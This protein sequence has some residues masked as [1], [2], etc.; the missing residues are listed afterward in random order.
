MLTT[1]ALAT[2]LAPLV[3][4]PTAGPHSGQPAPAA[5]H[6]AMGHLRTVVIDP[7]HGGTNTGCLGVDGTF[8]KIL[9]MQ[10]AERVARILTEETSAVALLTRQDDTYLGLRE[11]TRQANAWDGD[12]FLSLHLN[13][14]P[15]GR[16]EGV[17][18]WFL[19]PDSADAE[20]ARLV[21]LEEAAFAL[22]DHEPG[23][24]VTDSTLHA[25]LQDAVIRANQAAS[26][27]LAEAV[28]RGLAD[29]TRATMRGVRQARFGV[30][31]E[32]KMPAIVVEC[33][34][35]SHRDEGMRLLDEGYQ[36]RV[37]HGIVAGLVAFDARIGGVRTARR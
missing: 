23:E 7:G 8:E 3:L 24:D 25:M 34:F 35:F 33:G 4:V 37:A 20:A 26:E 29:T 22:D 2:L 28:A 10:I 27:A 11:R 36:E 18:T 32:A 13:A 12:V 6:A 17:E 1:A 5:P 14:D 9:T 15:Y 31:K 21:E 19:A 30:L 16:G